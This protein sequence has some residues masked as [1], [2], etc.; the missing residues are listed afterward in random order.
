M[1]NLDDATL[2]QLRNELTNYMK[3]FNLTQSECLLI[4][5]AWEYAISQAGMPDFKEVQ[6]E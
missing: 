4:R 3:R 5:D 2:T 1:N 6:D